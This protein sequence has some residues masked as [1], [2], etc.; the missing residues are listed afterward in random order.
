MKKV[1]TIILLSTLIL[2]ACGSDGLKSFVDEY[3][4]SARKY[5]TTELA[6]NE[7]GEM[8]SEDGESWKNL[9]QSKEYS[10]DAL[11]D[12]KNVVGY[13]INVKSDEESIKKDSKGYNAILTLA[14]VLSLDLKKL[15]DGMQKGFNENFYN[16]D[17]GEYEVRIM[18]INITTASMTVSVE[19]KQGV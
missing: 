8:E 6:E 7:F 3:N 15:E 2:V 9:F 19:Q 17:D 1:I 11:Y 5:D 10:I 13:S 14:D 12:N 4:Q 18:V 16:Y